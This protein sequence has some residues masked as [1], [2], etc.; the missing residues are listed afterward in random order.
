MNDN[1]GTQISVK[2]DDS[3]NDLGIDIPEKASFCE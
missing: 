2:Q 3:E 1:S